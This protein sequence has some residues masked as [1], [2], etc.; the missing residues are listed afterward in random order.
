MVETNK[1]R[2]KLTKLLRTVTAVAAASALSVAGVAFVAASPAH[3][4][5]PLNLPVGN[6]SFG[7]A[8]WT[9]DGA[10]D[11]VARDDATGSVGVYDG[12]TFERFEIGTGFGG[13]TPFGVADWDGDGHPDLIVRQDDRGDM[14][15]YSGHGG[16][17][18]LTGND[19][20]PIGSFAGYTPFGVADWGGDS[21]KDLVMR[22]D[23][24]GALLVYT[25]HGGFTQ[26]TA[27][28]RHQIGDNFQ[29]YTS[30]GVAEWQGWGGDYRAD[31]L[32]RCDDTGDLLVYTGHGTTPLTGNDRNLI[33]TGF[34]GYTPFGAGIWSNV[35]TADLIIRQDSDGAMLMYKGHKDT[36]AL[37][38]ADRSLLM[39]S[40]AAP[41]SV[42]PTVTPPTQPATRTVTLTRQ[43]VTQGPI[44][45]L[46]K[47]P[48]F[49]VVPPG[50]LLQIRI[51][52]IGFS[53]TSVLFV[54]PG[55]STEECNDPNA[56]IQVNEGQTTT[57]A[58][59]SA[60][61]G[62]S[63][64]PFSTVSPLYFVACI[65]KSGPLVDTMDIEI[66]VRFS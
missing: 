9:G 43:Q 17:T 3:A 56:V 49:G 51:P 22:Q 30:F 10:T 46:G 48:P 18:P 7:L 41:G 40:P 19:R 47:F 45:Y 4:S 24:T 12:T 31:L 21:H 62:Q 39:P 58:Q 25:G 44:P 27:S 28:D 35:Q 42:T 60:I 16:T 2:T 20:H 63:Q 65:G 66:T 37:S 29:G 1:L 26:L 32:M 5:G 6:T 36:M 54:K 13:Y 57:S 8:D 33:G 11:L 61:Y 38:G 52:Q 34:G 55:H 59:I 50:V 14:V 53:D 64:P 23:G 15:V